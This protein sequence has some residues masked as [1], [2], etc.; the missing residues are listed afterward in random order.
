[1]V[2]PRAVAVVGFK[3][4]GKTRVIEG[5]VEVLSDRG[6]RVGTLKHTAEEVTLDTPGKDTWR[7]TSAGARSTAILSDEKAAI[8]RQEPLTIHEAALLLGDIEI[9]L[10]EG[11]KSLDYIPRIIIPKNKA[12]VDELSNGL[13]IALIQPDNFEISSHIPIL[14]FDE[15]EQLADAVLERAIPLLGGFDCGG[16]GYDSCRE[17]AKAIMAGEAEATSCIRYAS[18]PLTVKVNDEKVE[19]N[20]F[21]R[22][23]FKNI[24]TGMVKPLR[25]VESPSKIEIVYQVDEY[26]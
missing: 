13:E 18:G 14:G 1:M 16:C 15:E 17:L 10:L 26:E 3:N 9:L 7:H 11:F 22:T 6:Y 25:G 20:R 24:V 8:F 19:L 5:I 21:V 12:E 4:S 2:K 23:L